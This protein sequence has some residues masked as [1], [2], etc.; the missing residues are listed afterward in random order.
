MSQT[1]IDVFPRSTVMKIRRQPSGETS[2]PA[3]VKN[4]STICV[5]SPPPIGTLHSDRVPERD[6][7]KNTAR[8]SGRTSGL[9]ASPATSWLKPPPRPSTF[10]SVNGCG[11]TTRRIRAGV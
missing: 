2:K 6:E 11:Q 3:S 7:T 1:T 9:A 10:Q 4:S 5:G 8:S